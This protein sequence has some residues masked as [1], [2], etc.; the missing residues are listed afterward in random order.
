MMTQ[1]TDK[2]F[3]VL[4]ESNIAETHCRKNGNYRSI[5]VSLLPSYVLDT[6][7]VQKILDFFSIH[8]Q[9]THANNQQTSCRCEG[10][11]FHGC[12]SQSEQF[13]AL[14]N[15]SSRQPTDP[16]FNPSELSNKQQGAGTASSGV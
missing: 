8:V 16:W 1:L 14:V 3:I 7:S 15:E 12:Q 13:K 5:V 9:A 11:D 10:S 6:S 2:N 4:F